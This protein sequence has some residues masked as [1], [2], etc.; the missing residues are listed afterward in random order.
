MDSPIKSFEEF[1][2]GGARIQL[3][4]GRPTTVLEIGV[5]VMVYRKAEDVKQLF[6]NADIT[7]HDAKLQA[8]K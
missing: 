1:P 7:C 2:E 8:C 5:S 4:A 6:F 3:E